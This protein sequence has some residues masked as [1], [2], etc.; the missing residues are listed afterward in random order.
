MYSPRTLEHFLTR[1]TRQFPVLLVTGP[2]Q[3]GK[4]TVL[5]H[6][7]TGKRAYVTLD[8]PALAALGQEEPALFLERFR[9]PVLID[10]IQYAPA[11]LPQIKMHVDRHKRA[12]AF[13]LTGSQHFQL[14]KG[15]SE[16]LAG[17]VG[18][19]QLLGLSLRELH[20]DAARADGFLPLPKR[21]E[22]R[23]ASGRRMSLREVY[24]TIWRG[25]FPAVALHRRTDHDLFYS[26][27]VQTYLE[28]DVRDLANVGDRGA[29][30]KFLRAAAARS[31]QMLNMSDMARDA[32]V[33]PATSMKWLAIL[34][35]SGIVYLLE[36]YSTNIL[37][38]LVR[39]PKLYFLDTGLCAY[40]TA[41]SSPETLEA[42][43]MSGAIL[44]TFM[45]AE[46][47][48]SYWHNGRR[49]PLFYYRDK[50]KK[51]IDLLIVQDRTVYPLEFKK[52]AA[53]G[54]DDIRHFQVL[55]HLHAPIGHGGVLCLA[56]TLLPLGRNAS[57]IP[58]SCL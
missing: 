57:V 9:P 30:L 24:R 16:S 19:V 55:E 4:T 13:W 36:P 46:I 28:R 27:Y 6:L 18:I 32:G 15:V 23:C 7:S 49:A 33:S 8:D 54:W 35:A 14:M 51:E 29:F 26:S 20:G 47:L 38:R 56:K 52:T 58:I 11:L 45:V 43:A 41:W 17:R 3:V 34:E 21:L 50:D 5:Q 44:E 10:E 12:G 48:K 25:A 39:A 1:A 2:R 31:G 37:K 42:G 22:K 40:L 53:P